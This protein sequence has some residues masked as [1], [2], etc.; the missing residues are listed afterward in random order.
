MLTN[1]GAADSKN[2]KLDK[3]LV[4][5]YYGGVSPIAQ[6]DMRTVGTD[7]TNVPLCG[8]SVTRRRTPRCQRGLKCWT[9]VRPV[10]RGYL[11]VVPNST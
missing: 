4:S 9:G 6:V 10:A 1:G 2:A 8:F 7:L 3:Y 11:R 5:G